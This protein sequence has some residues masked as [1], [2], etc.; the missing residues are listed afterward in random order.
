MIG[1]NITKNENDMIYIPNI[2]CK[3]C[4]FMNFMCLWCIITV[5]LCGCGQ[6]P[7]DVVARGDIDVLQVMLEKSPEQVHETNHLGKTPLHYAVSY[8]QSES[9]T[10]LLKYHA[11]IDTQDITG[12]TPLH[13]AAMLGR[14][15]EAILLLEHGANVLIEDNFGDTPL[16]TAALHGQG[17]MIPVFYRAG[18]SLT[19]TNKAGKTPLDLAIQHGHDRLASMMAERMQID[20]SDYIIQ[21]TENS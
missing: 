15:D 4:F 11:D 19:H 8:K 21:S 10:L 16:H 1:Q 17:H 13:L 6:S 14:H 9:I 5:L 3:Y 2:I 18:V 20:L 12:M 7:H